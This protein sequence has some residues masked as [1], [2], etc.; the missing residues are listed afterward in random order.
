MVPVLNKIDLPP[1]DPDERDPGDRGRDRHRR[2]ATRSACSAKTGEGIDDDPR[3][4]DRAH[5]AAARAIPEA[6]LQALIIDS[7]FDNYVGVVMLV[8]VVDGTL[9]PKDNASS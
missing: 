3:S 4:G 7:W 6:P 5:P 8:R 1:A 2:A 9:R